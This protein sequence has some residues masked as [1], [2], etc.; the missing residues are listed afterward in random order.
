MPRRYPTIALL[1]ATWLLQPLD[2][3]K[4]VPRPKKPTN[5]VWPLP[6]EK[7]RIKFITSL[8]NNLDVE[9]PK[10]KGWLQKLIDEDS[11]P[12]VIGMKQPSGVAVDSKE[13]IYV[14]DTLGEAVFVFDLQNKS[15][16]MLGTE[17]TGRLTSPFGIA[18]DSQDNVY[19]SDV[20]QKQVII[21]DPDWHVKAMVHVVGGQELLNPVGL[22]LDEERRRL[23]IVDS[24]AHRVVVADMDHPDHGTFFGKRGDDD[25]NFNFPVYAA[26]DKAGRIYV[27]STLGFS[28]KV[29][30]KDLKFVRTLGRHG[31]GVGMFDRPKGIALDTEGHLYVVDASFSN[32]Q[33]FNPDGRVLLY[34]GA[35]GQSPGFFQV[36]SAIFVDRKNRI[37]VS[38]SAN[39]R[40]QMF[41][42]LGGQ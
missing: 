25:D 19:V 6:P 32:F 1:A 38:D 9:P 31:D 36:P 27:T 37:Y 4:P 41:Q 30:D 11:T 2:A 26:V 20:K 8:A 5:L 40:I 15:L 35:L 34:V 16:A 23:I 13:R 17:P 29:F 12:N 3:K 42:F 39:K 22:A 10:Q 18:I 7:P 14:A 21:Y 33:I 28:V 24:H